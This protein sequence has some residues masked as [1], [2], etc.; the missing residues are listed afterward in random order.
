MQG[1]LWAKVHGRVLMHSR[2]AQALCSIGVS[3]GR[4][5]WVCARG[6]GQR[7][8]PAGKLGTAEPKQRMASD[9]AST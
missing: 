3:A 6:W 9:H 4:G 8:A 5:V 1:Q 7:A 2:G